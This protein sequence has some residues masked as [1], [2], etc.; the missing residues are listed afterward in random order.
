MAELDKSRASGKKP[1]FG[2]SLSQG[3]SGTVPPEMQPLVSLQ[4]AL[5]KLASGKASALAGANTEY[6]KLNDPAASIPTPPVHAARLSGLLKS[7]ANA[8]GAVAES[9]KARQALIEGLEKVLDKNRNSLQGEESEQVQLASR[10]ATIEAKKREVEDGIMRGLAEESVSVDAKGDSKIE[11]DPTRSQGAQN[12]P[13]AEP[14]PPVVEGL[15]PPSVEALTPGGTPPDITVLPATATSTSMTE[16]Q[17]DL[18]E[19]LPSLPAPALPPS[20]ADLLSSLAMPK[21]TPLSVNGSSAKKRKID[22]TDEFA[23]LGSGDAME[24]LDEDV[25]ETLRRDSGIYQ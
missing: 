15:S 5:S 20:G 19:P 18:P 9:I 12:A 8:E 22:E 3:S 1:L 13:S 6:D 21:A 25:K 16:G 10:K 7:L 14:E 4:A 23:V 17:P 2:G 24:G 11:T